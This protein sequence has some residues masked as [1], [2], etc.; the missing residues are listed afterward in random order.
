MHLKKFTSVALFFLI[1]TNSYSQD[2][3]SLSAENK[4]WLKKNGY[5]YLTYFEFSLKKGFS[6]TKSRQVYSS[7]D[8]I[9]I[10]NSESGVK[11]LDGY[12]QSYSGTTIKKDTKSGDNGFASITFTP[13][14]NRTIKLKALNYSAYCSDC[15]YCVRVW[16]YHRRND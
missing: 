4:L 13:E 5:S 14:Y 8:Y 11:D 3:E 1:F 2:C 15:H 16:V 9:F 10:F 6:K 7:S 12:L